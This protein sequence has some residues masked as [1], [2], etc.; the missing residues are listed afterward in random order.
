M[1]SLRAAIQQAKASDGIIVFGRKLKRSTYQST[2]QTTMLYL[3]SDLTSVSSRPHFHT[4]PLFLANT[5]FVQRHIMLWFLLCGLEKHCIAPEEGSRDRCTSKPAVSQFGKFS[6]CHMYDQSVL[7]ILVKNTRNVTDFASQVNLGETVTE[8]EMSRVRLRTCWN[9]TNL[10][11]L[12]NLTNIKNLKK[13]TK[14]G[15]CIHICEGVSPQTL[16]FIHIFIYFNPLR[17][18]LVVLFYFTVIGNE[19]SIYDLLMFGPKLNKYE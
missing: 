8:R 17:A 15:R 7:N 16:L 18:T 11:N 6:T 1:G 3:I 4:D 14:P 5:R 2:H 12:T 19:M 10:K 13:L 9:L